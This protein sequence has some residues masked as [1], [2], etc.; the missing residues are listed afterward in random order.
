MGQNADRVGGG[1]CRTL[2]HAVPFSEVLKIIRFHCYE[3]DIF[4]MGGT[5]M[6][7]VRDIAIGGTC[8]LRAPIAVQF[9]IA[10]S[11]N[12]TEPGKSED[13]YV[14]V[15][16]QASHRP[17]NRPLEWKSPLSLG[18]K[19]HGLLKTAHLPVFSAVSGL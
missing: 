5:E 2:S 17:Q 19:M 4:V 1:D 10:R 6:R 3:N 12:R 16:I 9:S 7:Q 14:N 15:V 8:G 18:V 11:K 13:R